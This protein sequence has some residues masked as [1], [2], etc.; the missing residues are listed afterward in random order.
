[1]TGAVDDAAR[2]AALDE[3]ERVIGC[4][5]GV[6]SLACDAISAIRGNL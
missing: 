4:T 1:M 5:R 3:V 6:P 2:E